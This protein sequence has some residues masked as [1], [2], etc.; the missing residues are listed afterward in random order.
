MEDSMP[1]KAVIWDIGGVIARTEDPAPRDQLAAELG[2]TRDRLN[3]LVFAGPE[4]SR[5]QLGE[6]SVDALWTYVREELNLKDGDYPN[7][8]EC[9]FDGD[10]IDYQIVDFI[11]SIKPEYITAVLSNAWDDM[12]EVLTNQWKI[13]DAFDSIT[14]SGEEGVKKPDRRIYEIVLDRIG[15]EPQEAVFVDDFIENIRAATNLGSRAI[16][17]SSRDQAVRDIKK[18]LGN[19]N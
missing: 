9:F 10:T 8:Q 6:I 14:I 12:R 17:F 18:L 7:L 19:E 5:A 13:A 2:V 15:V 1:I 16:H 4:G 3:D 11:R